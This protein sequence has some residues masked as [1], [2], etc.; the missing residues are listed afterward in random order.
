MACPYFTNTLVNKMSN[1]MQRAASTLQDCYYTFPKLFESLVQVPLRKAQG[2]THCFTNAQDLHRTVLLALMPQREKGMR[3]R[4]PQ[5]D[6]FPQEMLT[7]S[8]KG[9]SA[10]GG[11]SQ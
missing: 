7:A 6:A 2:E 10:T 5:L 8:E 11:T 4:E 3:L 1:Q 9:A